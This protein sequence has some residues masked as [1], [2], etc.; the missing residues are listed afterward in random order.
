MLLDALTEIKHTFGE[1]TRVSTLK[2]LSKNL[3]T[4]EHYKYVTIFK[5]KEVIYYRAGLAKYKWAKYFNN[6]REAAI[7]VDKKLIE[8]G[9]E[10]VNILKR[11]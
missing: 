8:K 11:K 3:G 9:K 1:Y 2:T 6:E 7:A 4:S 5:Y 10:P